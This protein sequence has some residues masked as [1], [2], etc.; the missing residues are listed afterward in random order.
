MVELKS[1]LVFCCFAFAFVVAHG[2]MHIFCLIKCF[3][4]PSMVEQIE[5]TLLWKNNSALPLA[6]DSLIVTLYVN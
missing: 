4:Q 5:H 6:Y 2:T 3:N 1:F